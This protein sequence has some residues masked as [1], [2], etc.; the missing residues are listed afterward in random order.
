MTHP[1][2]LED[3]VGILALA[4]AAALCIAVFADAENEVAA[5]GQVPA[6]SMSAFIGA[7]SS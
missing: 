7:Q 1:R 3:W 4:C 6:S 5:G 2:L